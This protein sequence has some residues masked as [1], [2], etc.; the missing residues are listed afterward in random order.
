MTGKYLECIESFKFWAPTRLATSEEQRY[1]QNTSAAFE[2]WKQQLNFIVVLW[3]ASNTLHFFGLKF[4]MPFS[5]SLVCPHWCVISQ[6]DSDQHLY[7]LRTWL[8]NITRF[9]HK[10]LNLVTYD[11]KHP[12]EHHWQFKKPPTFFLKPDKWKK[13]KKV[14]VLSRFVWP[15]RNVYVSIHCFSILK[16][17]A[18]VIFY[19]MYHTACRPVQKQMQVRLLNPSS[20]QLKKWSSGRSI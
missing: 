14:S 12:S 11:F 4:Y 10:T 1:C 16:Q 9:W 2:W 8:K 6:R 18:D 20:Y 3:Q 7:L 15:K 13:E 5:V 19:W 17:K